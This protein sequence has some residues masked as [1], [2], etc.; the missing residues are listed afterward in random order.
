MFLAGLWFPR[1]EFPAGLR[2]V[3]DVTPL[4][5]AVEALQRA[6]QSGF[7]SAWSLLILAGYAV[8]FGWLAVRFFRWE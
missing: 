8:V 7:P 2:D 5:A 6:M 3:S 1:Q 4:G